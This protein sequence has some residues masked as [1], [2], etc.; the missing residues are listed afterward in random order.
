MRNIR[1]RVL[2]PVAMVLAFTAGGI[3]AIAEDYWA[4]GTHPVA[5]TAAA[6]ALYERE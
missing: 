2:I 4:H 5:Y 1:Y 3:L 6:Q